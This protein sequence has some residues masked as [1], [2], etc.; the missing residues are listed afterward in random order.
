[1]KKET[2]IQT[3]EQMTAAA[4]VVATDIKYIQSDVTCLQ[5]DVKTIME[6]HLPHLTTEIEK[7]N[8]K[9]TLFTA[10]NVGAIIMGIVVSYIL[11]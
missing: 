3:L 11:K 10:I 6:N 5:Q 1:M 7:L 8:T 9:I 4:A 2:N